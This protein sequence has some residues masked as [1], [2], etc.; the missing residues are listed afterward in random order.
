MPS[1]ES[2]Y[3]GEVRQNGG[4]RVPEAA[5]LY[6][7]RDFVSCLRSV[8]TD[9]QVVYDNI[10]KCFVT[11]ASAYSPVLR[12]NL[13]ADSPFDQVGKIRRSVV[14]ESVLHVTGRSYQVNWTENVTDASSAQKS[15]RMRAVATVLLM[16]PN[17]ATIKRNPLGIYIENFEMVEL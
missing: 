15:S 16:S 8:S 5:I 13:L 12:R 17:E 4:T 1:G 7:L 11:A 6:Q 14:I 2:Q 10:D 9:Y 3:L